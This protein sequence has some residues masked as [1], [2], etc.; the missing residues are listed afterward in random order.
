MTRNYRRTKLANLGENDRVLARKLPGGGLIV[1]DE[2]EFRAY[3]ASGHYL[4]FCATEEE[5]LLM[6]ENGFMNT[7]PDGANDLAVYAMWNDA[8]QGHAVVLEDP[9]DP[10]TQFMFLLD[11]FVVKAKRNNDDWDIEILDTHDFWDT[12]GDDICTSV[13]RLRVAKKPFVLE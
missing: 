2:G 1:K 3:D 5:A 10:T 11:N 4:G 9:E 6:A 8:L 12:Y 7:A 13:L